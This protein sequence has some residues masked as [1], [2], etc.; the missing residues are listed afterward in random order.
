MHLIHT[1]NELITGITHTRTHTHPFYD[2]L[3]FV[4][5]Y[6]VPERLNKSGFTGAKDSEWQWYQLGHMQICTSPQTDNHASIPSL[7]FLQ[8]G[9][10]SCRP[11]DGVKSLKCCTWAHYRSKTCPRYRCVFKSVNRWFSVGATSGE[12]GEWFISSN[13]FS[14][15][16]ETPPWTAIFDRWWAEVSY[17]TEE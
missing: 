11:T 16:E 8:T 6:H 14:K 13:L 12:Y 4:R 10:P 15:F 1:R 2:P 3:D 17:A 5:D 7:S 9:C